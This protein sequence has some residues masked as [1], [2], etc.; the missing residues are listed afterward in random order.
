[1]CAQPMT[2]ADLVGGR[3]GCRVT[4]QREALAQCTQVLSSS[5]VLL[6]HSFDGV[7]AACTSARQP[8]HRPRRRWARAGSRTRRRPG[9][10][11]TPIE[12]RDECRPVRTA[13]RVRVARGPTGFSSDGASAV[14]TQLRRGGLGAVERVAADRPQQSMRCRGV[15]AVLHSRDKDSRCRLHSIGIELVGKHVDDKTY[16]TVTTARNVSQQWIV[17]ELI[18]LF[19]LTAGDVYRHP[20]VS[21]KNPG[22]AKTA[23]WQSS[24]ARRS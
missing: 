10:R 11:R 13:A 4:L 21:Y 17:G 20:E 15:C 9:A 14:E 23:Q 7:R 1:M 18:Q 24:G 16:E 3:D 19:S 6:N 5:T 22:E 8:R 12:R 2:R